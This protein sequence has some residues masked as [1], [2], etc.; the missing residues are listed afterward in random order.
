MESQLVTTTIDSET[1][2][3]LRM[4]AANSAS[5]ESELAA[6][7]I[8]VYIEDQSWQVEAIKEGIRQADAGK[9]ASEDRVKSIFVKWGVDVR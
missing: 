6:E 8:R 3:N 4:L 9:F 1:Y 2:K 7:A 5:T